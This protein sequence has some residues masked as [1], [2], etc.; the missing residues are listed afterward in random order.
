MEEARLYANLEHC[1]DVTAQF[2]RGS[3]ALLLPLFEGM[4][5]ASFLNVFNQVRPQAQVCGE[6]CLQ[7]HYGCRW[8]RHRRARGHTHPP[9][10]TLAQPCGYY[11]LRQFVA[12][13]PDVFKLMFVE[14][15]TEYR[16]LETSRARLERCV[17]AA[18]VGWGQRE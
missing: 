14:E 7:R 10:P 4:L 1:P 9:P 6:L 11:Q 3:S 8:R 18:S 17:G 15:V 13:S 12:G 16:L 2:A 5:D